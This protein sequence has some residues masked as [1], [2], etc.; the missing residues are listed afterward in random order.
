MTSRAAALCLVLLVGTLLGVALRTGVLA[1]QTTPAGTAPGPATQDGAGPS[2]AVRRV[3]DRLKALQAEATRLAGE[4]RTLIGQIRSLEIERDLRADE[5]QL[6]EAAA[7]AAAR[8]LTEIT[9]RVELLDEQRV[10]G[11]PALQAQLVQVY[12]RGR[13][14]YLRLLL[15]SAT[16]L[17]DFARVSRA[18]SAMTFREER[19]ISEHRQALEALRGERDALAAETTTLRARSAAAR[20]ARTLAA[21]AVNDRA[22]LIARIDAARDLTAQYVGE[23]QEAH[24]RVQEHVKAAGA[25]A[26]PVPSARFP[27]AGPWRVPGRVVGAFGR[28]SARSAEGVAGGLVRNGVEIAAA[29]GTPVHAVH[30]GAVSYAGGFTGLGSVVIVDHGNQNHTVYGYLD[31]VTVAPGDRLTPGDVVGRV[32]S[33]PSG[34]A[35]LYFE[36]HVDGRFVDPLQWLKP[37]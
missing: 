36:L 15:M 34:P 18:V 20:H 14:S 31:A 27:G 10:A 3:E 13:G 29:L 19:V 37:R 16:S 17:R 12:K 6:A 4:S 8:R 11:L 22:A 33:S 1:A 21:R 23:L 7:A 24:S 32:G 25:G 2:A 9:Q 5:A 30:D 26:A 28:P 35:A